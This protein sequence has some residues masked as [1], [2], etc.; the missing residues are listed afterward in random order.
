[1]WARVVFF[2]L[3]RKRRKIALDIPHTHIYIAQARPG[4]S[5]VDPL[6]SVLRPSRI[7]PHTTN[8]NTIVRFV[9]RSPSPL[10]CIHTHTP[11]HC[12]PA[13]CTHDQSVTS[14]A[15]CCALTTQR[16]RY[17]CCFLLLLLSTICCPATRP[18]SSSAP[19]NQC[20]SAGH[21]TPHR[22][23]RPPC[24]HR[25]CRRTRRIQSP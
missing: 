7:S 15:R 3:Y 11:N 17:C 22:P 19:R 12:P 2:A 5:P 13:R 8:L 14:F 24:R 9:P 10:L 6:Q 21:L 16:R 23:G 18:P 20:G 1:M 4:L 25:P